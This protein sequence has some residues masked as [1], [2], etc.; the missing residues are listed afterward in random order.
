M[1]PFCVS[2]RAPR[3]PGGYSSSMTARTP[4]KQT[5]SARV[6]SRFDEAFFRRYYLERAARAH[7]ARVQRRL[8]AF[9]FSY[10][11]YL[12]VPVRRVLD[13]GCG[14]GLWR[15]E[16]AARHPRATYTG[17]EASDYLCQ[18]FGWEQGTVAGYRG[19][20]QYDLVICQSVLQYVDDADVRRS[21]A[22]L[23]RLC[24][25]ALYLEI[26]TRRDWEEHCDREGSD[27]RIRLRG[28]QWYRRAIGKQFRSAGG[29]VF[30]PN[31]SESVLLELEGGT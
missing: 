27:G 30:L 6:R 4:P 21:I 7:D 23:A 25:G 11:D 19:R 8:A 10:L 14:L 5:A 9:V 24:R 20:G 22:N 29:G 18:T 17:V 31:E 28:G 2:P 15:R 12:E 1:R 26:P 16:L 13:L 3:K